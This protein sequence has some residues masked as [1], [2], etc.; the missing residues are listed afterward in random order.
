MLIELRQAL[1]SY[2]DDHMSVAHSLLPGPLA[3]DHILDERMGERFNLNLSHGSQCDVDAKPAS[4][5]GLHDT[6]GNVW[7]HALDEARPNTTTILGSCQVPSKTRMRHS[8]C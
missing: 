4:E 2:Q 1:I 7:Q 3:R 8:A 5:Q 6:F